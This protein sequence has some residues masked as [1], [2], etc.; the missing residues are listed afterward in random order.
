MSRSK[1]AAI[2][3]RLDHPVLDADGHYL[4]LI[5]VFMDYFYEFVERTGG[6]QAVAD[7]A[8]REGLFYDERVLGTWAALSEAERRERWVN[9]PPF[10]ALPVD[11]TD[12]ASGHLPRL[13]AHRL[14][15]FGIDY[16]VMYP[17]RA[18]PLISI[19]DAELRQIAIRAFNTYYAEV[20]AELSDRM[21]PVAVVPTHTPEEAIAELEYVGRELGCK[22][23]MLNGI[24][25]RPL[26]DGSKRTD[27]LAFDSAY[28]YDPVWQKLVDEKIVPVFHT[29]GQGWGSRRSPTSYVY[30]HIG[31]FAASGEAV[32]KGLF[33]GGVTRRFP[34]LRFALMEGGVG[35]AC[36]LFADIV[37]HWEK[38][39]ARAIRDLDPAKL[40][41]AAVMKLM[42]EWGDDRI[43]AALPA[44]EAKLSAG[45]PMPPRLDEFEAVGAETAEEVRDLFVPRFFFGCEADDPMVAWAFNDRL[46]PLG[47]TLQPMF[48]SDVGHWDVPEMA[49]VVEEAF[50]LVEDGHLDEAQ[51]RAF[52]FDNAVRFYAS[53]DP[54]FFAG[55]RIEDEAKRVLAP[56]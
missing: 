27:T 47:A 44:I 55:T 10:W 21:S 17:T 45:E 16:A 56:A 23:V 34:Q 15:E 6:R 26:P 20:F 24:V 43:R 53:L 51:F 33:L 36:N 4:E 46:N 32:C 35:Y 13:M 25:H 52:M 12:R 18:L 28:D 1:S 30:N 9:R 14:D 3:S 49:G 39:N 29:S 19:P 22:A 42:A 7:L 38:R 41:V 8:R 5:P 2:R 54:D 31:S 50:E 11:T 48:S 40:D 37:S